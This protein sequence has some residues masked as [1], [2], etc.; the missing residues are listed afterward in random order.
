MLSELLFT[1]AMYTSL[2]GSSDRMDL[3][4]ITDRNWEAF[5][6]RGVALYLG[7]QFPK[8]VCQGGHHHSGYCTGVI[9]ARVD[10]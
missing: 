4:G 1:V 5:T 2:L 7:C 3:C 6:V 9:Y 8:F 10:D